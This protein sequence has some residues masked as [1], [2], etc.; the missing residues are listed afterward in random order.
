V[1]LVLCD[2]VVVFV[3]FLTVYVYYLLIK[4]S[5][6]LCHQA[7][8]CKSMK[9][10]KILKSRSSL[11]REARNLAEVQP[12]SHELAEHDAADSTASFQPFSAD[13]ESGDVIDMSDN[14]SL[15]ESDINVPILDEDRCENMIGWHWLHDDDVDC[16]ME[17]R[18]VHDLAEWSLKNNISL[19]ATT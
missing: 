2:L 7:Q 11:W 16:E 19:S 12:E 17:D 6:T 9:K 8:R 4:Y 5:L 13:A 14:E 15:N 3:G 18:L 1:V 10:F